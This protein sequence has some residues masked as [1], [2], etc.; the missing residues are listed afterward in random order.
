MQQDNKYHNWKRKI[1]M[2]LG[3]QAI[4]LFGSA[5]VDFAIIWHIT[6]ET[7]SGK[8]LTIGILCSFIPRLLISLFAGVWTD[9]YNKKS[10]II[11]AD[12]G[13]ALSILASGILFLMGFESLM[14]IFIILGIRSIGSGIQTPAV[15]ALIPQI[16]PSEKLMRINGINGSLQS[17]IL[18]L[19]PAVSGTLLSIAPLGK[20][21]FVDVFTA[22]IAIVILLFIPIKRHHRP[23][24]IKNNNYLL[25]IKEGLKYV[26]TNI[27]VREMLIIYG[28]YFFLIAPAAFLSPLFLVRAFSGEV[29]Y[30]TA[31]EIAYSAGAMIGGIIIAKWSG[32]KNRIAIMAFSCFVIGITN[33]LLGISGLYLFLSMM[34]IMGIF[35]SFFSAVEMTLFQE[36]VEL[37]MQG[38]IFSIVQMVSTIVM[39][40]AMLLFGPLGDV[41][42]VE[43]LFVGC[44]ILISILGIYMFLNK[45]LNKA[46]E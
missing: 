33:L 27:F 42:Q 23:K 22:I 28:F 45:A 9:R 11:L 17:A 30:L 40:I 18:L 8:V 16:V 21:F 25:D 46:A 4:S 10:L 14:L 12:G 13:L 38:R 31:N 34:F 7:E 1:A 35:I 24:D 36:K 39:P 26:K 44:G 5:L 43:W 32:F 3:G 19:S 29:W 20:I 37:N 15:N 6:L 2:F 41:I